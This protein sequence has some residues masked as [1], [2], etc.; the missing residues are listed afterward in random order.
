M[1]SMHLHYWRPHSYRFGSGI[2]PRGWAVFGLL[3]VYAGLVGL[4]MWQLV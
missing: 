3:A 2:R 1:H 4:A